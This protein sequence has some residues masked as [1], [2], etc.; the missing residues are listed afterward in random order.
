MFKGTSASAG[1]GIGKA[2]IVEET[3]LK[4]KKDTITDVDA[5][6]A[7]FQKALNQTMEETDALAK[8]LATRV[9]EKEA[10]ILNGHLLLLSDPMLV[11]EIE[12][13]ISGE[14]VNSE[15]AIETVC[16]TYADMFASMGDELMQ[17]RAT[18][19]RDIKTRMQKILLGVSSVDIGSLPAGSIL[20]A[21]DLTPSMTAGINPLNVT[22]IVTELGG[23]TSHSAILARALEIPAVV[24]V[25]GFMSQ[26]SDGTE[27]ILDGS[28][29][30]VFS[31]PDQAVR[32]EYT[33]KRDT[34][35]KEKKELE[36]YIGKP[37]ITKDG[38][39][40]E[41]VANIGKPEDVEKVLQ[42]DGEGIGLFRTEFLFMDRSS[43]PTE[44][45]QFEAYRKVAAA[46]NGKPVIIRTLD[47]GGD[48][49]IPYMGLEK[50]ENPFLGYRAIRFC[51]D[52][53]EDVYRPQ[54]RALLR[55][56]AFGNIRIMVPMVT[57]LEEYREA[58]AFVDEIKKELDE[59]SIAYN[60][61]IQVGIMVET[62]AA[63]LMA[64]VFAREVDFFSI[65]TNDLTQYTMS[66]DRGN[67]KVSYLYSPLNPAVLRSIRHVIECGRKEGIMV[68]MCGEAA[69]DPLLIPLL[70]AF[71]LNEFSMSASAILN[72]RKLITGYSTQELK[73]VANKAMSF[74]TVKE[75]ED[76]MKDFIS[77][78]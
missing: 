23:K 25:D 13:T 42:Y 8:D 18:D 58:R 19:M 39:T 49:E 5:E 12:N 26:I 60:K 61:D 75:V 78:S 45:E 64:D 36:Q 41:L 24:A 17:Q 7:R 55:A 31:D 11:G 4:I 20:V 38:V 29:G 43:M 71:G 52:R 28:E 69:S 50:D 74:A 68:G 46:M 16:N 73:E 76:Y 3:E 6:K 65:G 40:I 1:I 15:Y 72:A 27:L 44:D 35:L 66:V 10:E 70:L 32:E 21:R 47:I 34:F 30:V 22:G 53:K 67:D 54:I 62:A 2:V 33:A 63:S 37:T 59:N 9:G 56:S 77:R 14:T 48:K 51:L 57:C